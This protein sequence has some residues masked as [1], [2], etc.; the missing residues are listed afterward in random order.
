MQLWVYKKLQCGEYTWMIPDQG[1]R[2]EAPAAIKIMKHI[3]VCLISRGY[4]EI[5]KSKESQVSGAEYG[6]PDVLPPTRGLLRVL[7]PEPTPS[8]A[9]YKGG[10]GPARLQSLSRDAPKK[11]ILLMVYV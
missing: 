8:S 4:Y 10:P 5:E 7:G 9:F 1:P 3:Q 6:D 2:H 11:T